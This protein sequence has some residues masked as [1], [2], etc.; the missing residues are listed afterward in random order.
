LNALLK[1]EILPQLAADEQLDYVLFYPTDEKWDG[2]AGQ[3]I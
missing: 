3:I 2:S 1:E